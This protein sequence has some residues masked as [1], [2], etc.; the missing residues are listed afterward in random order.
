MQSREWRR[1]QTHREVFKVRW[2]KNR[3]GETIV[4]V[5]V[6]AM[7]F[8]L[9]MAVL[10][11]AVTFSSTAQKKSSLLRENNAALFKEIQNTPFTSTGSGSYTFYAYDT[12]E[13]IRGNP[14]FSVEAGLGK[15][16]VTYP[17]AEGGTGTAHFSL[18]GGGETGP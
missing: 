13:T 4:E 14:V 6:S 2:M 8:L 16:D 9:L 18:F 11:G 12:G 10:Q 1:M 7:I 5:L 3:S 15:K 17:K